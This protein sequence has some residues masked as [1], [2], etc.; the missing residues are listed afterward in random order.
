MINPSTR[1][2]QVSQFIKAPRDVVYQ[3]FID[4]EAVAS[5][6][7]PDKMEGHV[8]IFEPRVG[9]RFRMSLTYLDQKDR[10]RGKSSEDT[11]TSEGTFIE[12]TP[13]EKIVQVFE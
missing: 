4:P 2:T 10:P 3:A 9:G 11:D 5:W 7:A 1:S 13:N 6:L 12:L 8:E